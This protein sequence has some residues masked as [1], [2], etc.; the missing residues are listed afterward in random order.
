[1]RHIIN[2]W[3]ILKS[4]TAI[5]VV[6]VVAS[7]L[8]TFAVRQLLLY[9]GIDLNLRQSLLMG[10]IVPLLSAPVVIV[11]IVKL[12]YKVNQLE[13]AMRQ[14]ATFDSLTGLLNRR[15]FLEQA[16]LLLNQRGALESGHS[17]AILVVDL[18]HFKKINDLFGHSCGDEV[19]ESF[20]AIAKGVIR[21]GDLA[22]RMGG[23]EF[24]FFLP[25]VT[26]RDVDQIANRLH[27]AIAEGHELSADCIVSYTISI[28]ATFVKDAL[29][30]AEAL[31]RADKALYYAKDHGRNQTAYD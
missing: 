23:E 4:C 7:L 17:A 21:Q 16:T 9:F 24:A 2:R 19:L 25:H 27:G 14:L 11:P 15:A 3:G 5:M 30:L 22:G 1:M 10:G 12:L 31:K 13:G 20:G 8:G 26:K 28:G 29:D 18:D 6:V